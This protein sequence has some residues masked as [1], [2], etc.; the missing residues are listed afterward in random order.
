MLRNN[1]DTNNEGHRFDDG[2]ASEYSPSTSEDVELD[3]IDD[4]GGLLEAE[5]AGVASKGRR[6][7]RRR[8]LYDR[9]YEDETNTPSTSKTEQSLADRTVL[10]ASAINV[11]LIA[12]WYCFS[13]S[14]SIVSKELPLKMMPNN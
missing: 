5:E 6:R 3:C 12:S 2:D 7:K 8:K 10:K 1:G 14:I 4:N 9:V 13:L 11:L